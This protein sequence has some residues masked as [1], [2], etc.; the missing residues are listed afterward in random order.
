MANKTVDFLI[1]LKTQGE[2]H[3]NK[4]I[5]S[6]SKIQGNLQYVGKAAKQ[7]DQGF[8]SLG[9]NALIAADRVERTNLSLKELT[10]QHHRGKSAADLLAIA[11]R[12]EAA[13]HSQ[14]TQATNVNS[15]AKDKNESQTKQLTASQQSY[16][17]SL[18]EQARTMKL[19]G[20]ELQEYQAAQMGLSKRDVA[21]Y[22]NEIDRLSMSQGKATKTAKEMNFA[23]RGLPA[24]FTDI[25][26]SIQGGQNP[27]Q[28]FLQQGGQLKDMFGGVGPAAKAMGGYI[29]GLINPY[30]ILAAAA[31]SL[32][33][34][35]E[36]V[37]KEQRDLRKSLIMT[38]K[39]A[40]MNADQ[41]SNM[42]SEISEMSEVTTGGAINAISKVAASGKFTSDQMRDVTL[43]AIAMKEAVGKEIDETV[44]DFE[45]IAD[46]P[47]EALRD[48]D[49]EYNFL[50]HDIYKQILALEESGDA[51]GAAQ[52][53]FETYQ[54]TMSER[55]EKIIEDIGSLAGVWKSFKDGAVGLWD[56]VKEVFREDTLTEEIERLKGQIGSIDEA[57]DASFTSPAARKRLEESKK[58]MEGR[59]WMKEQELKLTKEQQDREAKQDDIS[60][61]LNKNLDE[62]IKLADEM[63][64][65]QEEYAERQQEINELYDFAIKHADSREEIN[66]LEAD[67]EKFLERLKGRYQEGADAIQGQI[68]KLREL[69]DL[70]QERAD[71]D[72]FDDRI[73][74]EQHAHDLAML[75]LNERYQFDE[76]SSKDLADKKLALENDLADSI[77][78]IKLEQLAK[79]RQVA[80]ENQQAAIDEANKIAADAGIEGFNASDFIGQDADLDALQKTLDS[81]G[82]NSKRL[83]ELMEKTKSLQGEI[84][85][86][87]REGEDLKAEGDN[88]EVIRSIETEIGKREEVKKLRDE[89]TKER[90]EAKQNEIDLAISAI[91]DQHDLEM[92][93]LEKLKYQGEEGVEEYHAKRIEKEIETNSQIAKMRQGLIDVEI[94]A[95]NTQRSS[96]ETTIAGLTKGTAAYRKAVNDLKDVEKEIDVKE[97]EKD[98][99]ASDNTKSNAI[100]RKEEE[101]RILKALYDEDVENRKEADK[102]L[103]KQEK[104]RDKAEKQFLKEKIDYLRKTG[105][106]A[107]LVIQ[108]IEKKYTE[109]TKNL[110]LSSEDAALLDKMLGYEK[111]EISIESFVQKME[112]LKERNDL[113]LIDLDSYNTKISALISE[114]ENVAEKSGVPELI[115]QVKALTSEYQRLD[116]WAGG[117]AETLKGNFDSFT[118]GLTDAIM[119]TKDFGDVFYETSMNIIK[120]LVEMAVK[121][122]MFNAIKNATAG[123]TGGFGLV[124][125][126]FATAGLNH[127]GGYVGA[128]SATRTLPWSFFTNAARYHDGGKVLGP[129]EVPAVLK[130]NEYVLDEYD[131]RNP[132]NG[133]TGNVNQRGGGSSQPVTVNNMID[134]KS[135]SGSMQSTD[136]RRAII[137][138]I[139]AEAGTVKGILR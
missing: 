131:V 27:M 54:E 78:A 130:R 31:V 105:D 29:K 118:S 83:V 126:N 100:L 23:M 61:R 16:I 106:A 3:L 4:L 30:T 107:D 25:A 114:A 98:I 63:K 1:N 19:T 90:I 102:N 89:E 60:D 123:A 7:S 32:V 65:Q 20:R 133:G 122:A 69:I 18:K 33:V 80:R 43:T 44:G 12:K 28:V 41:L 132:K 117:T 26:V 64:T 79:E 108:G 103:E 116:Y 59:L 17:A 87:I 76:I 120:Q 97:Q 72:M 37:R 73:R 129:G 68:D 111:A 91:E 35:Y 53:A 45:K 24:Q 127:T 85:D 51:A 121:W 112:T 15:S 95:L 14:A 119:G 134:S 110:D 48:L 139:R 71:T 57:M 22:L 10:Y 84:N 40:Q 77:L 109:M 11:M 46:A 70:E 52:L 62:R 93:N 92:L 39:D 135:L 86:T 128:G 104:L 137:N 50:T 115:N 36:S 13:A 2:Q 9:D 81:A 49:D 82:D 5:G 125:N 96:L 99:I 88:D 138:V 8:R 94:E 47:S 58:A 75:R 136:G 34:A 74:E 66:K 56:G 124:M 6:M 21:P 42:A 67:R 101:N 38:G 113:G 55:S